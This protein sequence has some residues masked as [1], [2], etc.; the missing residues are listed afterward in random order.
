[1]LRL[2]IVAELLDAL[3]GLHMCFLDDAVAGRIEDAVVGPRI[4]VAEGVSSLG[5]DSIKGMFELFLCLS[6]C[7]I[8]HE[9]C[10]IA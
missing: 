9:D 5:V 4:Q 10:D 2:A 3:D 7:V 8:T 1:M 6:C